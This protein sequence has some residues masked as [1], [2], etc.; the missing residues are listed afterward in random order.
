MCCTV[1]TRKAQSAPSCSRAMALAFFR[2]VFISLAACFRRSALYGANLWRR[3]MSSAGDNKS[4]VQALAYFNKALDE[5]GA[6]KEI[7]EEASALPGEL[8]PRLLD[9]RRLGAWAD[10]G[11]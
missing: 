11:L 5:D 3:V 8:L 7:E 4:P 2:V 1:M 10:L 6:D 9:P